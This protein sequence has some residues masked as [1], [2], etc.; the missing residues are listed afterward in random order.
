[1]YILYS[2]GFLYLQETVKIY[3]HKKVLDFT[4]IYQDFNVD[5]TTIIVQN[6]SVLPEDQ[7]NVKP[8]CG[9]LFKLSSRHTFLVKLPL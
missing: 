7:K 5:T 6:R 1:M 3:A 9:P 8:V 2:I 4:T